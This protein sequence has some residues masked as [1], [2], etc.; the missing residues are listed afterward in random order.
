MICT[1]FDR[2]HLAIR[3]FP[4]GSD[5]KESVCN[6]GD[7]GSIPELGRSPGE[8]QGNPLQY[9]YLK[10]PM[11]WQSTIHRVTKIQTQLKQLSMHAS[12]NQLLS[13]NQIHKPQKTVS[14]NKEMNN[15]ISI[16]LIKK[17]QKPYIPIVILTLAKVIAHLYYNSIGRDVLYS[18]KFHHC[19]LGILYTLSHFILTKPR[20]EVLLML[21]PSERLH[22]LAKASQLP[23]SLYPEA[24]PSTLY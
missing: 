16:F 3:G 15:Y 20:A 2:P 12:S 24:V 6:A 10:N 5:S 1:A 18:V 13:L 23:G 17:N 8:G 4:G 22:N 11:D 21:P 7:S 9:S 14:L 19:D